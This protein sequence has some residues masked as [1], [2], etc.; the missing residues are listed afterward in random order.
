[1]ATETQPLSINLELAGCKTATPIIAKGH[2]VRVR[3]KNL[4]Q[5]TTDKGPQLVFEFQTTEPAPST[6]GTEIRPGF[7]IFERIALYAKEGAKNPTWFLEK[8]AR[9]VDALLGTGDEGN[10]K[11]KA[12]RPALN[13]ETV[14]QMIG[15][16]CVLKMTT[17]EYEGTTRSEID[18]AICL[19]DLND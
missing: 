14:A 1:M 9:R 16:E 19:S 7:P 5:T 11:G 12:P 6:D 8:I 17:S 4:S 18:K 10:N 3:L 2:M 15:Q 13:A